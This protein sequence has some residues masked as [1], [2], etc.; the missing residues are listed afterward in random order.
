M[1]GEGKRRNDKRVKREATTTGRKVRGEH[2]R[3]GEGKD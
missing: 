3:T 2:E 1:R